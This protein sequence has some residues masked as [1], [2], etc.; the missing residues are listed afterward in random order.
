M[1]NGIFLNLWF[2]LNLIIFQI[3][4]FFRII[5]LF[6]INF[7]IFRLFLY[8]LII[9]IFSKP[10]ILLIYDFL[11]LSNHIIDNIAIWTLMIRLILI[12]I[13]LMIIRLHLVWIEL[14]L[15]VSS[16]LFE[17]LMLFLVDTLCSL[18]KNIFRFCCPC[19]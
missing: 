10:I 8:N 14:S 6:Q 9:W 19:N 3:N 18:L 13:L 2:I 11:M 5:L 17:Y 4:A 15:Q 7:Y 12:R 16:I 1:F